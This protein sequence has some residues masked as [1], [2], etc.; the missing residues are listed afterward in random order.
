MVTKSGRRGAIN[1]VSLTVKGPK[2]AFTT[3]IDT[4][5]TAPG[6][7]LATNPQVCRGSTLR[8]FDL[9]VRQ[10]P[11]VRES[12]VAVGHR[13]QVG[14]DCLICGLDSLIW[15]LDC[16]IRG[17]DCLVFGLDYQCAKHR[18]F[19]KLASPSGIVSS[20]DQLRAIRGENK[21]CLVF[22]L[23]NGAS[24]GQ[25][26]AAAGVFVPFSPGSCPPRMRV[27][28]T[29]STSA[30]STASSRDSRR[31]RA[32]WAGAATPF[33]PLHPQIRDVPTPVEPPWGEVVGKGHHWC[34]R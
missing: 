11:R 5:A 29:R 18:E 24:Q 8:V 14:L 4:L 15:G 27:S 34:R 32:S 28:S 7:T 17:L 31:R 22:C 21:G 25:N 26:L 16:L 3:P 23:K 20:A 30:S 1:V 33:N 10:A 13:R 19:A 2:I 9:P 12:R 6:D